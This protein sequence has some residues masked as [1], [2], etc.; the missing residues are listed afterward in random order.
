MLDIFIT[1]ETERVVRSVDRNKTMLIIGQ[2]DKPFG[3][4]TIE[5]YDSSKRVVE[6]YGDNALSQAF[7][8]A[9]A[10]GAPHVFLLNMENKE[11]YIDLIKVLRQ[12][13]FAYIT[14]INLYLSDFFYDVSANRKKLYYVT[15]YMK[16]ASFHND[17]TMILTDKHASLYEH[18]DHFLDEMKSHVRN[19]SSQING[20]G[21]G[22][23]LVFVAN[24]LRNYT[25]ANV[26]LGSL[27]CQDAGEYP[28]LGRTPVVFDID[29]FD[30]E[31]EEIVYFKNNLQGI[32]SVENLVNF[33]KV[34][35]LRKSVYVD[36]IVKHIVRTLD[37]T[38]LHG[39]LYRAYHK[40]RAEKMLEEYFNALT[41]VMIR[42]YKI[43]SIQFITESIGSGYL[44]CTISIWPKS[45]V[46]KYTLTIGGA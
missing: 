40:L 7:Q 11:D 21:K 17:S 18:I 24:N 15:D 28:T 37:M 25:M 6:D 26:V 31:P 8:V 35:P 42:S 38:S 10:F 43:E 41:D 30:V 32:A 14:P 44:E 19:V 27:L 9:K 36:R 29:N 23:N 20:I 2:A 13:D 4:N 33:I 45:T 16:R 39:N 3:I 22:N 5:Y 34:D 46:G 1:Q 12:Y